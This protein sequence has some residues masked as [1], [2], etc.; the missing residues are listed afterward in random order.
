MAWT[1]ESALDDKDI[2]IVNRNDDLGVYEFTVGEL[3]PVVTVTVSLLPD[4]RR[5]RFH[6]SHAIKTPTQGKP[7]RPSRDFD[8]DLPYALHRA[9]ASITEYYREAVEEGHK[10]SDDW[11]V[12]I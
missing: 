8:D 11:L 1:I 3:S 5:A 6:R 4:G 2:E 9:I 12:E 10:P 7:Y